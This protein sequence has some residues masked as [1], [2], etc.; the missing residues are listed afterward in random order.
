MPDRYLYLLV[1]SLCLLF[2]LIFTFHPKI[3]FYRHWRSF[4]VP[5]L[6]TAMVFILWDALFTAKGIWSFNDRYLLGIYLLGLPLEEYL[7]FIFI[8][9][10]CVFLY[11]NITRFYT[12]PVTGRSVANGTV[13]FICVLAF[14]AIIYMPLLYTSVTFLLLA[15][16]LT[17]LLVLR[18]SFL[19]AFYISFL[20]TLIPFFL[21][22]GVLT[23]AVTPQPVVI[24]NDSYNLGIRL[25]T[26]PIED[27]FYGMA[28]LLM[29]IAGFEY[30]KG[31]AHRPVAVASS[32]V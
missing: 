27:T 11:Y 5:C 29:N 28:M 17:L 10:A 3:R 25:V 19:P 18:A 6:V 15:A 30:M 7:F 14:M 23:G 2:P 22:N 20:V 31:L 4:F 21:S 26:I 1:D 24:Y 32:T 16:L 9:Y 13:L 12:I 8:P